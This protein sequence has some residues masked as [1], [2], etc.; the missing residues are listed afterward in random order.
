MKLVFITCPEVE[1]RD[2]AHAVVREHLA[3]AATLLPGGL[4][5]FWWKGRFETV[6]EAVIIVR[7]EEHMLKNLLAQVRVLHPY[8]IPELQVVDAESLNPAYTKWL[9][10][11]LPHEQKKP[12]A[13]AGHTKNQT[14]I[15]PAS[16]RNELAEL[17]KSASSHPLK[18]IIIG[19]PGA[20]SRSVAFR[21]ARRLMWPVFSPAEEL[22]TSANFD[23]A[24]IKGEL[25]PDKA[26]L[27]T[28][29]AGLEKLQKGG[30]CVGFPRTPAQIEFLAGVWERPDMV[31]MLNLNRDQ[32]VERLRVRLSCVCGRTYGPALPPQ[33]AGI[34]NACGARLF[35]R[36]DD[37]EEEAM[38]RRF[39]IWN[40]ETRPLLLNTYIRE[41]HPID[42][43]RDYNSVLKEVSQALTKK[44]M[45]KTA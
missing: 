45:E 11:E 19:A 7:T 9:A 25:L 23:D 42:G 43:A 39:T 40:E 41:I 15:M 31:L 1:A 22:I 35:H 28:A 32:S 44:L 10:E 18:V 30:V 13:P 17:M 2:I 14:T 21:I 33:R 5:S 20:G 12:A 6:T 3:A 37:M 34:C 38:I 8:E 36:V 24:G 16:V 29:K 26:V 27:K 4:S